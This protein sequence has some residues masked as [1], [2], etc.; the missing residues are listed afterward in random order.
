MS[1]DLSDSGSDTD[2]GP[3]YELRE[4]L[5]YRCSMKSQFIKTC[6]DFVP[7]GVIDEIITLD[8]VKLCMDVKDPSD[9]L[10]QFVMTGAKRAFATAVYAKNDLKRALKWL[11]SKGYNDEKL[12]IFFKGK[13]EKYNRGWRCDFSESQ[14]RFFAPIFDITKRSHIFEEAL[15]LPFIKTHVVSGEGSFGEVS[16]TEIHANHMKPVSKIRSTSSESTDQVLVE[17]SQQRSVRCQRIEATWEYTR[18]G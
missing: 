5:R 12:P 13:N 4:V 15:I 6:H 8:Q 10:V 14:W 2:Q 18:S 1:E 11:K 9:E 7:E 16:K 3:V 17:T